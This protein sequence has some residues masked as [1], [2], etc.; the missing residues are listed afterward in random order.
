MATL[1]PRAGTRLF[2]EEFL[3]LSETFDKRKMELDE[4]ELHIMPRPRTGHQFLQLSLGG[5][6]DRFLDE[7]A[8]PPAEV[9]HDCTTS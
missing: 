3:D 8:E 5:Y 1:K 9:L 4:G 7:Y 6:I 2:A